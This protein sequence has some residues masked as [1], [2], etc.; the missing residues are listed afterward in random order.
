MVLKQPVVGFAVLLVVLVVNLLVRA[1]DKNARASNTLLENLLGACI[2]IGLIAMA[3]RWE[4]TYPLFLLPVLINLTLLAL[5][6]RSLL[7]GHEP[8]IS[9]LSRFEH[10]ELPHVLA[11]YTRRVMWV[12][13]AFFAGITIESV[14]LAAYASLETWSLFTN[15]LNYI[16]IAM[17]F[18]GDYLYR[19]MCFR[20]YS[21]TPILRLVLNIARRGIS[22]FV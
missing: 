13:T 4:P 5:F 2:V 10:G 6:G 8:I 22:P 16:F 12:W 3:M 19:V 7:S 1:W 15:I 11:V 20:K 9:R 18:V 17:L 21:Q 14:L